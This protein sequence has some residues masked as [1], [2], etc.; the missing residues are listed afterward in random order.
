LRSIVPSGS[1][2]V[3]LALYTVSLSVLLPLFDARTTT[4]WVVE[5]FQPAMIEVEAI[6]SE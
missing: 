2:A 4:F 3:L 6:A 5:P 1:R